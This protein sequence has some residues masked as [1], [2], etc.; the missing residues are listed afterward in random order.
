MKI[1]FVNTSVSRNAGGLFFSVHGLAKALSVT[2]EISIELLGVEDH[3]TQSDLNLWGALSPKVFSHYGPSSF[4]YSPDMAHALDLSNADLAHTQGLWTYPSLAV[5]QWALRSGR[6]YIVTL[7]GMLDTWALNNSRWKKYLAALVYENAHLR[8]AACLHALCEAEAE[9]I[10]N[11]GLKNPICII[12]NGIPPPVDTSATSPLWGSLIPDSSKV[13]LYLGRLHPKKGLRN[14]IKGWAMSRHAGFL[15]KDWRLVIA[16]WDQNEHVDDLKELVRQC[17]L[18][19]TVFFVGPQF[20]AAKHTSYLRADAFILPSFS[21]GL[22]MVVLEAWSYG[23]PVI[24]TSQCNLSEGFQV[25]AALQV[26]PESESIASGLCALFA[27]SHSQLAQ[28]GNRGLSL[29]SQKFNWP[30]IAEEMLMVY[31]WVLRQGPLPDCIRLD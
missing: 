24:M 21:E 27:M 12:P 30:T 5:R 7:H 17:K 13:L 19:T 18:E 1:S 15:G 10:R 28:M 4:C 25:Q 6:P 2:N 11:Y 23:L 16:G 14:L 3:F 22:P 31:R 9:A 26:E 8:N 20:E 29:V